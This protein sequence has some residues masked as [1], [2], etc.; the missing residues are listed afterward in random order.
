MRPWVVREIERREYCV[1]GIDA[2][3]L[4]TGQQEDRPDEVEPHCGGEKQPERHFRRGFLRSERNCS[5][6]DKQPD[7]S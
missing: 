7:L 3:P 1:A 5:V 4:D 6:S 2:N